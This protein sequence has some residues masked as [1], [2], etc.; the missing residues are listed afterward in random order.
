[1]RDVGEQI[2]QSIRVQGFQSLY[3]VSLDLGGFTVIVGPS[4]SGKSA[5]IRSVKAVT[6]NLRGSG[7]VSHGSPGMALTVQTTAGQTVTFEKGIGANG[8]RVGTEV[9]SKTAGNVPDSVT[10]ALGVPPVVPGSTWF[11]GQFD[12]PYLISDPGSQVASVIGGLSGVGILRSAAKEGARRAL[13]TA[14]DARAASA[15]LERILNEV[16]AYADLPA[17]REATQALEDRLAE[18]EAQADDAA[19]LAAAV[20]QVRRGRE[21]LEQIPPE[22]PEEIH[23][24]VAQVVA[25]SEAIQ[26]LEKA[27]AQVVSD[28]L[29]RDAA[30]QAQQQAVAELARV[31]QQY[32]EVLEQAGVCPTCGQTTT[33]QGAA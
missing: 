13:A 32:R 1:M 19:V 27:K 16:K 18:V 2:W 14:A 4:S 17:R 21:A 33:E 8:Y 3:D 29:A 7:F 10:K 12:G 11:A 26:R 9:F 28:S 6:S 23:A 15:S 30:Q 24:R 31:S 20:A 25:A 22:V 5:F